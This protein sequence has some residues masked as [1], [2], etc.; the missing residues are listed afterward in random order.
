MK[1]PPSDSFFID[2]PCNDLMYAY[3][4]DNSRAARHKQFVETLWCQTITSDGKK[5]YSNHGSKDNSC[6]FHLPTPKNQR[7]V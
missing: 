1:Y 3:I 5:C 4:R 2:G 6:S 7:T